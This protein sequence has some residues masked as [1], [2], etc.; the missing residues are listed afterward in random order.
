MNKIVNLHCHIFGEKVYKGEKGLISNV[1][2]LMERITRSFDLKKS[3]IENFKVK[4]KDFEAE[5]ANLKVQ[6]QKMKDE[7]E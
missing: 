1:D 6:L 5:V 4:I 3:K 7:W 2:E